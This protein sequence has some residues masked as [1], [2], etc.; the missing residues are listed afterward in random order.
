MLLFFLSM[1]QM[2]HIF[3]KMI[4]DFMTFAAP[5]ADAHAR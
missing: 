5:D 4:F 2:Q 1:F 3:C